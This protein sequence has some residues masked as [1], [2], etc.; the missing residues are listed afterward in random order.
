M[1]KFCMIM[2]VDVILAV[3]KVVSSYYW[4]GVGKDMEE[5]VSQ[6]CL[7]IDLVPASRVKI[8]G[9]VSNSALSHTN[10]VYQVT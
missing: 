1:H 3:D 7:C 5:W 4:K 8:E 10:T 9:R 6:C 2:L